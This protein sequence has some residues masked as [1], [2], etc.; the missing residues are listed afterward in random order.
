MLYSPVAK[1]LGMNEENKSFADIMT[2]DSK[3]QRF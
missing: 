1:K 2:S 3:K